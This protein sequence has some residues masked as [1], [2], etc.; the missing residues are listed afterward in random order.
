MMR[1]G[2]HEGIHFHS[3]ST[4]CNFL[5][6]FRSW[7]G[8]ELE[9]GGWAFLL[10]IFV[11]GASWRLGSFSIPLGLFLVFLSLWEVER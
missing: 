6:T 11:L 10:L 4:G 9:R 1:G 8:V 2:L 7:N 3:S 5:G